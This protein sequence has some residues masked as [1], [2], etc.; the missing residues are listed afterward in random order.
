[1]IYGI[2]IDLVEIVRVVK[3]CEKQAFITRIFTLKE[4][5]LFG[6]DLK[7]AA[8]NFAVKEAVVKMFGTG[9]RQIQPIHIEVLRDDRGKPYINLYEAA[10]DFAKKEGITKIHV[11]ITNTRDYASVY[12]V[13]EIV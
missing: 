1:M 5:E 7:K 8:S 10:L 13:G 3:A 4:Q 9:F 2:G 12:V 6:K 11:T